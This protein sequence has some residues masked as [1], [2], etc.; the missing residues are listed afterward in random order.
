MDIEVIG[1]VGYAGVGK[2]TIAEVLGHHQYKRVAFAD[3]LKSV[4]SDVCG[5]SIEMMYLRE[6]KS[7][8]NVLLGGLTPRQVLQNIGMAFRGVSEGVWVEYVRGVI[9]TNAS[10]QKASKF[11]VTDVRFKDEADMVRNFGG[12]LVYVHRS[13]HEY[14]AHCSEENIESLKA[15]CEYTINNDG[16][17]VEVPLKVNEL[18]YKIRKGV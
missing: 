3:K 17:I 9:T 15:D 14:H 8:P 7:T 4:V 2:D 16:A 11:V 12:V 6:L 18:L 5:A 1:L 10:A 13:T